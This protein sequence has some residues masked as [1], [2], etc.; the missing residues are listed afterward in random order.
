MLKQTENREHYPIQSGLF[1]Q[2]YT[3]MPM[4]FGIKPGTAMESIRQYIWDGGGAIENSDEITDYSGHRIEL[5][6]PEE[7]LSN[8]D[9]DL[10]DYSYIFDCAKQNKLLEN[11]KDYQIKLIQK[12]RA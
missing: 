9:R 8:V 5:W 4:L 10:F 3:A 12:S 11:L 6:D 1:V 2:P 7:D